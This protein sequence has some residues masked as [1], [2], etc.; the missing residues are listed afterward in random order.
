MPAC[1]SQGT[2]KGC[3]DS[4]VIV[5]LVFFDARLNSDKC[6][7]IHHVGAGDCPDIGIGFLGLTHPAST[8]LLVAALMIF[9][10]KTIWRDAGYAVI[11]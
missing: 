9:T 10:V 7:F 4:P 3:A 11:F 2:S 8:V 5:M 1:A 6:D